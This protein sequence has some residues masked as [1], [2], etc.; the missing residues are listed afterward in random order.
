MNKS[1]ILHMIANKLTLPVAVLETVSQAGSNCRKAQ[2]Q[3]KEL[4]QELKKGIPD[5][6]THE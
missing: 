1:E 6:T 4:I 2:D 5:E 3:I